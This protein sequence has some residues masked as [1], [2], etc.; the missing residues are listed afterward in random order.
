M[1]SLLLR[2]YQY[3]IAVAASFFGI[4]L[5]HHKNDYNNCQVT[6]NRRFLLFNVNN[7][8]CFINSDPNKWLTLFNTRLIIIA[9]ITLSELHW[10]LCVYRQSPSCSCSSVP[11]VLAEPWFRIGQC[12]RSRRRL[13]VNPT[14]W[15][16]KNI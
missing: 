10:I 3:L 6:I 7:N 15:S 16:E 4:T 8:I 2:D 5:G 14:S 9:L 13:F 12:Q 11:M 1:K